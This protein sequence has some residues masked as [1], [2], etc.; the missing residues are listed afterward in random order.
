MIDHMPARSN[1]LKNISVWSSHIFRQ[2]NLKKPFE[3]IFATVACSGGYCAIKIMKLQNQFRI[4]F[5]NILIYH[6]Y[7]VV[8]DE[9]IPPPGML[10]RFLG[11]QICD[12]SSSQLRQFHKVVV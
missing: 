1:I 4:V 9:V 3:Y 11:L 6:P 2:K 12:S 5:D 10:V 8:V 7:H